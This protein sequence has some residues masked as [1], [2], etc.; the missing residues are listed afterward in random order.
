ML[1]LLSA[2][3]N[4]SVSMSPNNTTA[5]CAL[6]KRYPTASEFSASDG[7]GGYAVALYVAAAVVVGVL[8][9]QFLILVYHFLKYVPGSRRVSTLWVSF[10]FGFVSFLTHLYFLILIF[11]EK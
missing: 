11:N 7:L 5:E 3:L 10:S 2:N 4:Y 8:L 9:A 6:I 1:F